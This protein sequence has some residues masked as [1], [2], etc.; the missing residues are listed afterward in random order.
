MSDIALLKSPSALPA[1]YVAM[2]RAIDAA[3]SVDEV[4]DI[5][6]RAVALEAYARQ[7]EEHRSRAPR[8]RNSAARRA[9]SRRAAR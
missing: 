1:L 5:R 3:Y 9:Q 7:S 8:L 4:K 2:C 6:D